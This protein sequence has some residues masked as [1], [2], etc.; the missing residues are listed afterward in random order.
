MSGLRVAHLAPPGDWE[1][2]A[3]NFTCAVPP[4]EFALRRRQHEERDRPRA[5]IAGAFLARGDDGLVE[6]G[7]VAGSRTG[8]ELEFAGVPAR[9]VFGTE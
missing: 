5:N 1:K 2:T 6:D 3:N 7:F 4:K 8:G 9:D